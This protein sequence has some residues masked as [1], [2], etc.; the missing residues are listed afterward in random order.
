MIPSSFDGML[1]MPWVEASENPMDDCDGRTTSTV[2]VDCAV[3]DDAD[4]AESL[5]NSGEC[6]DLE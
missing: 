6:G 1:G 5:M 2:V 4:S 3:G